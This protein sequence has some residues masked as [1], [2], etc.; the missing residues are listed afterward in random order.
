MGQINCKKCWMPDTRPGS[1]FEDGV[2]GACR[3]YE[4]RSEID[5]TKRD[6]E[7]SSLLGRFRSKKGEYDVL[8]PVSGGKDSHRIVDEMI[9]RGMNPLL[10]T[11]TDSFTH[12]S[13]GV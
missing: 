9:G 4:R 3:N 10:L 12:T 8:I 5:W 1:M 2:C 13:A 7:L 6:M 11:V